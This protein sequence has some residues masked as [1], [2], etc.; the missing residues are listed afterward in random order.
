MNST[1]E[2]DGTVI[3]EISPDEEIKIVCQIDEMFPQVD[4]LKQKSLPGAISKRR[5]NQSAPNH[6]K[7]RNLT[8]IESFD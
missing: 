5:I 1:V 6:L 2:L 3:E 4:T 7:S 8:A